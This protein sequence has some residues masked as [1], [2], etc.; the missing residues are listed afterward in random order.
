M[1]LVKARPRRSD[2]PDYGRFMLV[3][4]RTKEI[5]VGD[6]ARGYGLSLDEAAAALD[7]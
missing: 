5:V 2:K 3:D 1:Q 7:P 6:V 4:A